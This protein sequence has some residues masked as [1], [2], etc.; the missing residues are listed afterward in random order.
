MDAHGCSGSSVVYDTEV[1]SVGLRHGPDGRP[2]INATDMWLGSKATRPSRDDSMSSIS[3]L[4]IVCHM[5]SSR[6]NVQIFF[7]AHGV[8]IAN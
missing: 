3:S 8:L 1:P 7:I 4:V 2:G 5:D 6:Y